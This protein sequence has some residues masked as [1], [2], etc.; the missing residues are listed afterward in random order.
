M[1]GTNGE[2]SKDEFALLAHK[3]HPT[4]RDILLLDLVETTDDKIA[5]QLGMELE[6]IQDLK[7]TQLYLSTKA[8]LLQKFIKTDAS[9]RERITAEASRSVDKLITLRDTAEAESVQFG[10]AKDLLD[11]G[12]FGVKDKVDPEITIIFQ[13]HIPEHKE[14]DVDQDDRITIQTSGS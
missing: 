6:V 10:A 5:E 3:L 2:T 12:G 9:V 1:S 7:N 4:Y 8:D 14:I 11:R 13:S